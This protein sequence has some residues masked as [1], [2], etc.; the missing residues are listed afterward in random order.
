MEATPNSVGSVPMLKI[1]AG[2][3]RPASDGFIIIAVLW[4][5]AALSAFVSIYAAYVVNTA[6]GLSVYDNRLRSQQLASAAVELLAYR[7]SGQPTRP[8]VGRFE[9]RLGPAAA[10]VEF[11]SEAGRIDLNAAPKELL[12][13]LFAMLGA[14]NEQAQFYAERIVTW[15]SGSPNGANPEADIY[16]A[17]KR[18]YEPRAAKFP[19]PFEL[20]LVRGL[21]PDLVERALPFVTV[22]SGRAQVNVVAAAPD[23]LAALPEMTPTRLQAVLAQRELP[24]SDG[25]AVLSLMGSARTH[26]TIEPGRSFRVRIKTNLDNGFQERFETVVLLFEEGRDPLAV[27]SWP[28]QEGEFGFYSP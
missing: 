18:G 17:E 6:T 19:H 14:R 26:A 15:R 16:R 12:T 27:L 28:R 24:I 1:C 9:F 3:K 20:S 8:S 25:Q 7:M 23:L 21:P 5:L 13:G 11:S 10:A 2:M 22:Y 4:I